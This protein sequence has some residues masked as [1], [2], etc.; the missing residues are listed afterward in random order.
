MIIILSLV[1]IAKIKMRSDPADIDVEANLFSHRRNLDGISIISRQNDN[2]LTFA[3]L[4]IS[5]ERFQSVSKNLNN[6]PQFHVSQSQLNAIPR[7]SR[8]DSI[9]SIDQHSVLP[10]S[11][12]PDHNDLIN[13]YSKKQAMNQNTVSID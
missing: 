13:R 10:M 3:T 12:L 8:R 2:P 5:D 6:P 9:T 7:L 4:D 11:R 1:F